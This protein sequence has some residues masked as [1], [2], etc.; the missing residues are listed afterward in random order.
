MPGDSM[1]IKRQGC[2]QEEA[3]S[4]EGSLG[5]ETWRLGHVEPPLLPSSL[6]DELPF[7]S[8]KTGC[9]GQ[10]PGP[11]TSSHT[12]MNHHPHPAFLPEPP[13]ALTPWLS[14]PSSATAAG[15]AGLWGPAVSSP[16]CGTSGK[17][18][19]LSDLVVSLFFV[20]VCFFYGTWGVQ[21]KI[22]L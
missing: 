12:R 16:S 18:V 3:A 11:S 20:C 21:L 19:N 8:C 15:L 1:N 13:S 5:A 9:P 14:S 17:L 22:T 4:G 10:G 7:C 2:R 6:V